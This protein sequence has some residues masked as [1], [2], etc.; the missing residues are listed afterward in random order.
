MGGKAYVIAPRQDSEVQL[1][2][3][4]KQLIHSLQPELNLEVPSILLSC[5]N[6]EALQ[7]KLQEKGVTTGEIQEMGGRKTFH[8]EDREGNYFAVRE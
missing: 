2:I 8:F 7:Q 5:K 4:N 6:V 1:V 3:H